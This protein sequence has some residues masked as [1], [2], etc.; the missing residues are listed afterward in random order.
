[1]EVVAAHHRGLGLARG[2]AGAVRVERD[3]GVHRRV[4]RFDA[5]QAA[6]QQLHRRQGLAADQAPRLD[7]GQVA[8]L[9]GHAAS[10]FS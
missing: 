1:L 6:L 5:R 4:H 8:G 7:G 3:H 9:G 2:A 10:S